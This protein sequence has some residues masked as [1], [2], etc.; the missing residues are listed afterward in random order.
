[1]NSDNIIK[2]LFLSLTTS[3]FT[4]LY[5]SFYSQMSALHIE[6]RWLLAALNNIVLTGHN[7]TER[8]DLC[9]ECQ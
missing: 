9:P 1:M 4:F 6:T 5:D 2:I 7:P 8:Q 3:Y